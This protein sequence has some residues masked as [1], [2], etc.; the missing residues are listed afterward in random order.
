MPRFSPT[1]MIDS[2]IA[3]RVVSPKPGVYPLGPTPSMSRG[4]RGFETLHSLR[5]DLIAEDLVL[6][7]AWSVT[8]YSE[9]RSASRSQ[10]GHEAH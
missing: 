2:S 8:R 4:S 7:A 10:S 3:G 6:P 5:G 1:V 9:K